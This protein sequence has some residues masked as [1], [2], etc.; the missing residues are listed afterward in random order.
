ML[1]VFQHLDQMTSSRGQTPLN[2]AVPSPVIERR[3]IEVPGNSVLLAFCEEAATVN[4]A[5]T[6]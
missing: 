3:R 2:A 4:G 1:L 6:G 5:S